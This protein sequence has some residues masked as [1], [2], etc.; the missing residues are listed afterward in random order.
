M[1]ACMGMGSAM[2]ECKCKGKGE[3]AAA[4]IHAYVF[5]HVLQLHMRQSI[6][7]NPAASTRGAQ[8]AQQHINT[9][10]DADIEDVRHADAQ[11]LQGDAYGEAAASQDSSSGSHSDSED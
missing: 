7:V 10:D 4:C 2:C 6:R 3:G 1:Q 5:A 11:Y 9:S 8:Q